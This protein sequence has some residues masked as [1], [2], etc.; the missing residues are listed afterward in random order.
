MESSSAS[1]KRG[2]GGQPADDDDDSDADS[3]SSAAATALLE[4]LIDPNF[5]ELAR[6]FPAF[7][8]AWR[9][10]TE[11]HG[12]GHRRALS[13]SHITQEFSIALT[14]A[15]LHVHWHIQLAHVPLHHLCPP[16]PNRYF[17]VHW[18]QSVLL[19]MLTDH[20]Y[21]FCQPQQSQSK[22]QQYTDTPAA[23]ISNNNT[24]IPVVTGL[25]IGTGAVAIYPLLFCASH[26]TAHMYATDLCIDSKSNGGGGGAEES[27]SS[28]IAMAQANVKSNPRLA[29][30]IHVVAVPPSDRQQQQQQQEEEEEAQTEPSSSASAMVV[31]ENDPQ[32]VSG[33]PTTSSQQQQHPLQHDALFPVG[34]LRRS[35]DCISATLALSTKQQQ[36][37]QP[38][39]LQFCMTNPPFYADRAAATAPRD[40]DQRARTAMTSHEGCYPGGEVGFVTDMI[41][42]ALYYYHHCCCC[43][44]RSQS[45]GQSALA[46]QQPPIWSSTMCGK[47]TSWTTL[48]HIVTQLLGPGRVCATE[49]GPGQMT[50]WF[51][52]WNLNVDRP[53]NAT[54][55]LAQRPGWSFTVPYW[56]PSTTIHRGDNPHDE[57]DSLQTA[58]CAEM[59]ERLEDYCR[60]FPDAKLGVQALSSSYH[61]DPCSRH[62]RICETTI[63]P[64]PWTGDESLPEPIRTIVQTMDPA[65]RI[66][67]LPTEGHLVLDV[68]VEVVAKAS[69]QFDVKVQVEAYQH[70]AFG[71]KVVEKIKSQLEGEITRTNRRWRR[72]LQREQ[73]QQ[74]QQ[75]HTCMDES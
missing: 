72:K 41:V 54:S 14:K 38:L 73:K 29:S 28:S 1:R 34:P 17:Y 11:Q 48:Q 65:L 66:E 75:D 63:T 5:E 68:T 10:A 6:Q 36:Q 64:P 19:P 31:E 30:R 16:V 52:A 49:F 39:V 62:L 69:H 71:K 13:S 4:R 15:V 59:V 22:P 9:Q 12:S 33:N 58:A 53:V 45:G 74:Q 56:P 26:P 27:S 70:S 60:T 44:R 25:D 20:R 67:F 37:A 8:A 3:N 46:L 24:T 21:Y 18:I 42:D 7:G 32:I 23:E 40:G 2:R 61:P 35:L 43:L 57:C 51:L 47:K 50:R 55:P